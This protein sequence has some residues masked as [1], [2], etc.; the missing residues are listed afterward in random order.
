MTEKLIDIRKNLS[1]KLK[2]ERFEHTIG[3]MYTAASLAMCYGEDIEKALTAGLLHDC[4][5]FCPAK[6]QIRLCEKYAISLSES[7]LAMP[8]LIHAKLG[9]YL[10]ENKYKIKDREILDAITWHTTGR[11]AMTMLEKI[12]YIADYIEPNRKIIPGL[13]EIRGIV[14]Q[15]ID[16]A[17][18]L[19][20]KRTVRYLEDGGKS[21]DPMTVSTCEYY[22]KEE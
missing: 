4:G 6:E 2:K 16:R 13:E 14:F 18:Y 12:L 9:A 19:S 15:D 21:V 11:P 10:A 17:I 3:V 7:E 20:A 8:A 22:K 5:K 1:K